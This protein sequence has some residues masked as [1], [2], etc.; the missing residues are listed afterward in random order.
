M[1]IYHRISFSNK[2]KPDLVKIVEE[3]NI[4]YEK[5]ELP[6]SGTS[7]LYIIE[8]FES[9]PRWKKIEKKIED[10]VNL[11]QTIF[12][13]D[14]ILSAKWCRISS[15]FENGFPQPKNKW[16]EKKPNLTVLCRQCGTYEQIAGFD[17][18]KEPNMKKAD[19]MTL[20]WSY[21]LFGTYKVI[22]EFKENNIRG[23]EYW[24]VNI[25]KQNKPSEIIQQI[26]VKQVLAPGLVDGESLD[27]KICNSCGVVKY[28][29][30]LRGY[31]RMD[32]NIFKDLKVDFV[33]TNEWFG[34]GAKAFS[35]IIISNMVARTIIENNWRGV[36]LKPIKLV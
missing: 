22:Q 2:R 15:T 28:K 5:K 30:H 10:T 3:Q 31:M 9:D 23:V 6:G 29:P 14:E 11:Y 7:F 32:R 16:V 35:E 21:S 33:R 25:Y 34:D 26:Y 36:L 8:I 12:D 24:D 1:E 20:Y 18:K 4:E 13:R 27:P 19:F 17:I